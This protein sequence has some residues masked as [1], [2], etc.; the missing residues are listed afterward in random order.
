MSFQNFIGDYI[1]INDLLSKQKTP[2]RCCRWIPVESP[3]RRRRPTDF[4]MR[5]NSL[6]LFLMT[7][8]SLTAKDLSLEKEIQPLLKSY[9][10]ECHNDQ[11]AKGELSLE[12]FNTL[13]SIRKDRKKWELVLKNVRSGEM[14]P[15]KKPQPSVEERETLVKFVESQIFRVDPKKPDPGRVTIRRLNRAEYNNTIRDLVG[16]EFRPAD[17]FPVDDVGYGFDNIG[18]VLSLSPILLEKYL[19]AAEK[20]LS[21]AIVESGPIFDGPKKRIE[22]ET[23]KTTAQGSSP[24]GGYA[25]ALN[26]EGEIYTTNRVE[27][28]GEYIIRIRAFGQQFGPEPPRLELR[29]GGNAVKAFDVAAVEGKAADYEVKLPLE[30]GEQ[31]LAAAYINNYVTPQ[32]DRNLIIDYI[33][34]IGPVA[35]Q[36]YP[37]THQNIFSSSDPREVIGKFAMRAFRRPLA[38]EEL[39]RLMG[40]YEM[41]RKDGENFESAVR[42]ALSAVLISPHFLFRGEIQPDPDNPKAVHPINEFALASRLSYFLWSTMPDER[43]FTLAGKKALR[44]NLR[45]E[46]SRMLN[47][48]RARALVENFGNQWLQI[49]NLANI[50]PDAKTFPKWNAELRGAMQRETEMFFENLMREDRSVLEL[51]D[52]DYSFLNEPLAK[53]YGVEGVTGN[54]FRKVAFKDRQRGGVLTQGS[55]LAITSNPTRTSPVKRGKWILENIL[56]TPPPPPPPNVPELSEEKESVLSG[57]LRQ[58]MEQHREKPMCASCHSRMD[59]IG[60]GFENFDG[61]GAWR[62]KD[63]EFPVD[64]AG[65]LLS[66]EDFSDAAALKRILVEKKRREFLECVAGKMLTF[67]LGRGMEYYDRVSIDQAVKSME[68]NQYRFSSLVAGVVNSPAF[69]L[70]RGEGE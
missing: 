6:M 20:I 3:G 69:Q 27:N 2:S 10:F 25:F 15:E 4:G 1:S 42:V 28:P 43:L 50:T 66:G 56:G 49:R 62:E 61:I 67:A 30:P 46:V 7:V 9:C 13:E 5:Y 58:R 40:L 51:L 70:R 29:L 36:P 45:E 41:A 57:S 63:G 34:V 26:K 55:I 48:P 38:K 17:D 22:A 68:K 64:T 31:R 24:Y 53:H 8:V 60:F 21:A 39:D 47:D 14:P 37:K 35:R 12:K 32:G 52:A 23:L 65:K 11:K 16:V 44:K 54:E 19:S 33:D 59:P 18:D